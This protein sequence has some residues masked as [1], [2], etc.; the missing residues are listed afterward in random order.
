MVTICPTITAQNPHQYRQQM[1]NIKDFATRIHIDLM[2]GVFV[3]TKSIDIE[4]IWWPEDTK[5]D[6]HLMIDR[7]LNVLK[8]VIDLKPNMIL[9]HIHP[10]IRSA[11]KALNIIKQSNIVAGIVLMPDDSVDDEAIVK[12]LSIADHALIFGGKLGYQ[13]GSAEMSQIG[14]VKKIRNLFPHIEIG[15][16]GGVNDENIVELSD[17]GLS[18]VNVG[19]F[20]QSSSNPKAS[21]D[22]LS[23]QLK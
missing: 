21:Y 5:A 6:L 1:E 12:L 14:K 15:W 13:G 8:R 3:K 20:I 17:S 4:M 9:T 23:E 2:D 7:P 11:E 22:L 10:D 18:V 19:G 16:D